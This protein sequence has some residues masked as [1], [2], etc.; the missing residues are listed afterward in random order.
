MLQ[1]KG[2]GR[3]ERARIE[4]RDIAIDIGSGNPFPHGDSDA[5]DH[6]LAGVHRDIVHDP[7]VSAVRFLAQHDM[8]SRHVGHS[9]FDR[10]F[11]RRR[12]RHGQAV[13]GAADQKFADLLSHIAGSV[14][15]RQD[16]DLRGQAKDLVDGR[17]RGAHQ[18]PG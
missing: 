9:L 5:H 6:R 1:R 14:E 3:G 13:H 15:N 7:I 16:M 12:E 18:R 4:D 11:K 10:G 2:V 17:S 8:D